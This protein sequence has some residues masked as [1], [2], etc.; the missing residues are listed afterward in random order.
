MKKITTLLTFILIIILQANGQI[1]LPRLVSNGMVLQRNAPLKIWGWSSPKESINI[2]FC[3]RL[4]KTTA[5]EKGQWKIQLTA[6]KAGGPFKMTL[7]GKNTIILNDILIGDVWLCSGQSNMELPIR[8]IEPRYRKEIKT[9]NNTTI[10]QFIVPKTYNLNQEKNRI[11]NGEWLPATHD[12]IMNFSAVGYFFAKHIQQTQHVAIGLINSSL[13]GSPVEAW[14]SENSLTQFP[15]AWNEL[16]KFK[17]TLLIKRIQKNDKIRSDNWFNELAKKDQG[18]QTKIAWSSPLLNDT[19]WDIIDIPGYWNN[20]NLNLKKTNGTVWF[21]RKIHIPSSM[22][23]KTAHLEM[24]RIVDADSVFINGYYVGST[25][26]QYPPRWYQIPKNILKKGDNTI[27]VKVISQIGIGGFVPDKT[28]AI[29]TQKDT[30]NLDGKWKYK[31]GATMPQL[32]GPTFIRWKPSGL[33]NAMIHPL[34]NYRIKGTIWYQGESNVS[35]AQNYQNRLTC[36]IKNWRNKWNQGDFPFLIVQL[37]NY[38]RED[39]LPSESNLA[40]LRDAQFKV[41]TQ[42]PNSA[43][44]SAIDLGEWND[45]HPLN[46]KEIGKRIALT[47]EKIAYKNLTIVSSGPVCSKYKRKGS[48]FELSYTH[49]GSGLITKKNAPLRGYC[50]A[51]KNG[52]FIWADAEIKGSKVIVWNKNIKTP[53]AIRYG[54]ANNP[55]NA[56]LYNQ[57]GLP[58]IPFASDK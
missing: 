6:Q 13:G 45:I 40:L 33:Y 18:H 32:E 47:A 3:D 38:L 12:N 2:E 51:D 19:Q 37:A 10:R 23:N 17:D 25:S 46:K 22:E 43:M 41:A 30:I 52:K 1:Q 21:R 57:E 7:T 48:K 55:T 58:A 49:I 16:K 54:W 27:V 8:R 53:T 39:S 9:I 31:I 20:S 29:S 26:Y 56:N 44:A 50:I 28:Y 15:K 11:S 24:G 14:I 34:L 35:Q 42:L 5:S 4:Y 36:M